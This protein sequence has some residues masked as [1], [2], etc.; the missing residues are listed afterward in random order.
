MDN[1]LSSDLYKASNY[2][3]TAPY[4]AGQFGIKKAGLWVVLWHRFQPLSQ[5]TTTTTQCSITVAIQTDLMERT[6]SAT[7]V[8]VE[9][10]TDLESSKTIIGLNDIATALQT[11]GHSN[12]FG[13]IRFKITLNAWDPYVAYG[14]T[15]YRKTPEL[16]DIYISHEELQ[17]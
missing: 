13:Y 3:I 17:R 4:T 2:Y 8:T 12:N 5:Y 7:Y 1:D 10:I 11:A 15:L 14:S 6:N 16:F 9:T